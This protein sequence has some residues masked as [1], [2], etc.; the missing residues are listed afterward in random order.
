MQRIPLA[1]EAEDGCVAVL[2]SAWGLEDF[3]GFCAKGTWQAAF[4]ACFM[5][6]LVLRGLKTALAAALFTRSAREGGEAF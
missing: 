4:D 5:T 3:M 2:N 1:T 6:A